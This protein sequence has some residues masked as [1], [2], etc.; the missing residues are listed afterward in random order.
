M[1]C[2]EI[3][4]AFL[5]LDDVSGKSFGSLYELQRLTLAGNYSVSAGYVGPWRLLR[6]HGRRPLRNRGLTFRD[7]PFTG[8]MMI[9]SLEPRIA[10]AAILTFTDIDGDRVIVK[11]ST[12]TAKMLTDA[13]L[14][15]DGQIGKQLVKLTLGS[16]FA[17]AAI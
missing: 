1:P 6:F 13:A 16:G 14:F 10:P 15:K 5:F 2:R 7:A 8:E 3:C 9:E 12:G 11:S 17:N 4:R